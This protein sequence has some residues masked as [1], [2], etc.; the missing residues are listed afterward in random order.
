MSDLGLSGGNTEG[1][2]LNKSHLFYGAPRLLS[3]GSS[4]QLVG[5]VGT[6][7]SERVAS[8]ECQSL[9]QVF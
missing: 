2:S 5:L 3:E 9:K 8:T 4:L 6:H 1:G 7:L